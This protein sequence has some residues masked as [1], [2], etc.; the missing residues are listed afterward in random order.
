MSTSEVAAR[1]AYP[2]RMVAGVV[3]G[4]MLR[5]NVPSRTQAVATAVRNGW[6]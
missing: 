5:L 2:E 3:A 4:L 6:V 1:L